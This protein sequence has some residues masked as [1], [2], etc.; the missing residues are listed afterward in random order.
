MPFDC[1]GQCWLAV[2]VTVAAF[3]RCIWT[4]A[5]SAVPEKLDVV[6][7]DIAE[8]SPLSGLGTVAAWVVTL[9]ALVSP[10]LRTATSREAWRVDV[11]PAVARKVKRIWGGTVRRDTAGWG[12]D[13]VGL[14]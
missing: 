8:S 14:P 7:D 11:D 2:V 12:I 3:I 9:I 4:V 6:S 1:K 13:R 10:R 5:S